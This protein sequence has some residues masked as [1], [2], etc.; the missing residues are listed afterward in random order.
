[1]VF[2]FIDF[3]DVDSVDLFF[4]EEVMMRYLDEGVGMEVRVE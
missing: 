3:L 4:I 1:M 2:I